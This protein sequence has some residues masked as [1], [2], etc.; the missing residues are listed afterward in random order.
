M[1]IRSFP[2]L[3]S[4]SA[5]AAQ[6]IFELS[7][8]AIAKRGRF[9]LALS[10]GSTPR[11]LY[12]TLASDYARTMDWQ[13][14][15][16][17]WGDERYVSHDDTASNYR[18]AKESLLDKIDI[19]EGNIHPILTS[20][21]NPHDV[22][23]SY[24]TELTSFFGQSIPEFDLIL[25]GLGDDGHTASLF[26][27]MTEEEM[28]R[29]IAIVTNSPVPPRIRISLTLSA[30]NNASKV[31]FIVAGEGKKIILQSVLND[32]NNSSPKYPAS[33]VD[34]KG[35]L[36]WFVDEAAYDNNSFQKKEN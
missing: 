7:T 4:L 24:A 17:F 30:I 15:H 13:H 3:A 8:A 26:P 29:E 5:A 36:V 32:R 31:A 22:A 27:G 23:A 28:S 20:L 2:S 25:L 6:E 19:T 21:S 35:D 12:E 14:V 33:R 18:M 11:T 16:F 10:G 9:T 34:P 1:T